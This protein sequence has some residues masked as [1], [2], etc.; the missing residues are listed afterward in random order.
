MNIDKTSAIN[1][2]PE[3]YAGVKAMTTMWDDGQNNY[4]LL[5]RNEYP[6]I[7]II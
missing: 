7:L 3:Q 1:L 4:V 5:D 2:T 6:N